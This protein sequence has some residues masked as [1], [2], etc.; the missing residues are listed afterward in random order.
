MT[1]G[2]DHGKRDV[3]QE[4][5]VAWSDYGIRRDWPEPFSI[6][7]KHFER[8]LLDCLRKGE[9]LTPSNERVFLNSLYNQI[10]SF[11]M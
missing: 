5:E 1:N 4:L 7:E 6:S 8:P 10:T 3:G 11:N 9:I 2:A